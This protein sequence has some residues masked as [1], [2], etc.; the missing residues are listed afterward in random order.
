M[1]GRGQEVGGVCS[2]GAGR[3]ETVIHGW[4]SG[5]KKPRSERNLLTPGGES[6][7]SISDRVAK[8]QLMHE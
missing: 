2:R 6:M 8:L 1:N 7:D 4:W 3:T 5:E